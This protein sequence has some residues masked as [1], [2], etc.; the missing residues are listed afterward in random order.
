MAKFFKKLVDFIKNVA[1]DER[2][3]E[4]DK[5]G[6]A[7]QVKKLKDEALRRGYSLSKTPKGQNEALDA[8]A[9]SSEE[10]KASSKATSTVSE[11]DENKGA[12]MAA[13][14]QTS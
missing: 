10:A 1:Q 7:S 5:K 8:E 3:P 13:S 9:S 4:R 6:K 12:K 2:I 14:S 11:K